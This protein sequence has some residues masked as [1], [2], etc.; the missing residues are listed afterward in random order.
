MLLRSYSVRSSARSLTSIVQTSAADD[1]S[2]RVNTIGSQL[3]QRFRKMPFARDS[4]VSYSSTLVPWS[5]YSREKDEDL[6]GQLHGTG[7]TG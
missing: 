6:H 7:A 3:Q 1:R 4:N 2:P 5:L